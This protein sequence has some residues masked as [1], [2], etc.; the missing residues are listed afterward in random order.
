MG[1]Q[2]L[3]HAAQALLPRSLGVQQYPYTI[4]S[5][6]K[7]LSTGALVALFFSMKSLLICYGIVH[8]YSL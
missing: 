4:L 8:L 2:N 5:S 1:R 3:T 6:Q 7:G